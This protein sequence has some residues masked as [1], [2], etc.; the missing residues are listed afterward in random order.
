[1]R[2][3]LDGKIAFTDIACA[4]EYALEKTERLQASSYAA[5]AETDARARELAKAWVTRAE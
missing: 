1:M 2:A 5:L 3:F 4:M